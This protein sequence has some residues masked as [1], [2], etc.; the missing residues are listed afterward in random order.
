MSGR[1][2]PASPALPGVAG[3]EA[4][5]NASGPRGRPQELDGV[6]SSSRLCMERTEKGIWGQ[7]DWEDEGRTFL[8]EA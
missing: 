1:E 5:A 2:A 7:E 8:A 6:S 3:R 4:M